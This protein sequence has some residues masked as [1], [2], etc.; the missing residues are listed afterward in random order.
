MG[1][2]RII[3]KCLGIQQILHPGYIFNRKVAVLHA[4]IVGQPL[5]RKYAVTR[6]R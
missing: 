4:C 3:I 6:R 1:L 5:I 2:T